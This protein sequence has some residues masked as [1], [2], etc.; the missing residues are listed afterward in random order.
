M[1]IMK[2]IINGKVYDTETAQEV[3]TW[4]NNLSNRRDFGWC[5]ETL[6][7]KKTGEF[8]LFG[9]GG[10]MSRYAESC[11]NNTWSSGAAITPL[12]YPA[13]MQWAEEHLTADEYEQIFGRVVEDETRKTAAYSLSVTAIEVLRRMAQAQGRPASEILDELILANK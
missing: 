13:A 11:G 1:N 12:T 3:G 10:P 5:S 7:R 8:F 9:E 2:K 4:S 6:Y